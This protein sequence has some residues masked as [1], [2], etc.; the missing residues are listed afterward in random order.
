M[1]QLLYKDKVYEIVSVAIDVHREGGI[2]V[3]FG[4]KG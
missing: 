1:E 2:L 3:N 4:I